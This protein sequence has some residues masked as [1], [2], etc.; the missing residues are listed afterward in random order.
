MVRCKAWFGLN[1]ELGLIFLVKIYKHV[2]ERPKRHMV[3]FQLKPK[4]L[5]LC[6]ENVFW[7]ADHDAWTK[8]LI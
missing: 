7:N 5:N 1:G 3:E 8:P 4:K 2:L 6:R